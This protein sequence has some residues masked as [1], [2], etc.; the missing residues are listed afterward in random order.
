MKEHSPGENCSRRHLD[1]AGF[2]SVAGL[3]HPDFQREGAGDGP[4][5]NSQWGQPDGS[6]PFSHNDPEKRE[7]PSGS[8]SLRWF[9]GAVSSQP[10]LLLMTLRCVCAAPGLMESFCQRRQQLQTT[11]WARMGRAN[12][13]QFASHRLAAP[14]EIPH[15]AGRG[16]QGAVSRRGSA[17]H[18]LCF[19]PHFPPSL[20]LP[21]PPF[22]LPKLKFPDFQMQLRYNGGNKSRQLKLSEP[23]ISPKEKRGDHPTPFSPLLHRW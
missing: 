5:D 6:N 3:E 22:R 18:L 4:G 16:L 19:S 10:S 1:R 9:G 23:V 14:K 13:N 20:P 12:P 15:S 17:A 7:N 8:G 21:P 2:V 11:G